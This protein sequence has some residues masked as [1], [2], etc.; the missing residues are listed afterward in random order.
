MNNILI[1]YCS[2]LDSCFIVYVGDDITDVQ[3]IWRTRT[4]LTIIVVISA[5]INF[6]NNARLYNFVI[7]I[8]DDPTK[9][10]ENKNLKY[11]IFFLH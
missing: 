8:C 9:F 1:N 5:D 3:K 6:L 7:T 2:C 4:N 10:K 11:I